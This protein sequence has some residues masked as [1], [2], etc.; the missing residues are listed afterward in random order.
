MAKP[1]QDGRAAL[2][3]GVRRLRRRRTH[4]R[5]LRRRYAV[6]HRAELLATRDPPLY[7]AIQIDRAAISAISSVTRKWT[8]CARRAPSGLFGIT[9]RKT[10]NHLND[11]SIPLSQLTVR[12]FR[13]R[14]LHRHRT[15]R[16]RASGSC[17]GAAR[18]AW[19]V[20]NTSDQDLR[21]L[22]IADFNGDHKAD[23]LSRQSPDP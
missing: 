23:V 18:S 3:R 17:R 20:L 10:W 2:E 22:V 6:V 5:V 16:E 11:S 4:G 15:Q 8:C 19:E 9:Y 21:S 13:R 14:R 7:T 1:V 12:R